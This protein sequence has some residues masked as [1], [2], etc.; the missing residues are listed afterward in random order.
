MQG[1]VL[2]MSLCKSNC[3]FYGQDK[4]N[5]YC[6]VCYANLKNGSVTIDLTSPSEMSIQTES[7]TTTE[8]L[9]ESVIPTVSKKSMES[10]P[11]RCAQCSKK[12]GLLGFECAC[13][14]IYCQKCRHAESHK[15]TYDFSSLG[16]ALIQKNNP[17]V[18]GM[19]MVR[20]D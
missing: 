19:K 3:G 2:T 1:V 8:Q 14:G 10:T 17:V 12:V 20:M 5:G 13:K 9:M 7:S 11:S 15:C 4:L 16:K 6:S 18:M